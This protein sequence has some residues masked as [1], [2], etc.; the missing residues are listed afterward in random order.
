[1]D[2]IANLESLGLTQGES[3]A[4]LALLELGP[5]SAG[6]VVAQSK[7]SPSK[8]YNVLDRLCRKGLASVYLDGKMRK[9]KSVPPERLGELF[10][11]KRDELER[12]QSELANLLPQLTSRQQESQVGADILLGERGI[13]YFFDRS[14]EE[15]KKG[16]TIYTMGYPRAA[17]VAFDAYFRSFHKKRAAKGVR[18]KVIY[19]YD[20]WFGKKRAKRPLVDQRYLPKDISTPAFVYFW[21]DTVG[22]IIISDTQ[23]L[24]FAIKN[25]EVAQ[26]YLQYFELLWK[27]AERG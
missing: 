27:Q 13:R 19:N 21:G 14:L 2:L 26:S 6:A 15:S 23:K 20:A 10:E 24:C 7:I 12:Q 25:R 8:V 16:E 3:K 11:K 4:Y 5:S 1:M 22:I 18:G 17:S 9:Y